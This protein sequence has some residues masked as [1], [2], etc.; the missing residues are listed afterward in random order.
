M[1]KVVKIEK[2]IRDNIIEKIQDNGEV[3]SWS[4]LIDNEYIEAL[5]DKLDEEVEEV[6][7]ARDKLQIAEEI[8]DVLEVLEAYATYY[9]ISWDTI[10]KIQELKRDDL[11]GFFE[12][13]YLEVIKKNES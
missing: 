11:G 3:P 12:G 9:N 1:S 4:Y 13:V 5:Q 10:L 7:E 2:L 6:L 8:G